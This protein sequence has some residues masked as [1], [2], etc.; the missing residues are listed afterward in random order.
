LAFIISSIRNCNKLRV[1]YIYNRAIYILTSVQ[2]SLN[3]K[4]YTYIFFSFS[5]S[6]LKIYMYSLICSPQFNIGINKYVKV[7]SHNFDPKFQN[8]GWWKI[9]QRLNNQW[10]SNIRRSQVG[11]IAAPNIAFL[12]QENPLARKIR[13]RTGHKYCKNIMSS[14]G[15]IFNF[16]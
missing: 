16:S 8:G 15:S 7:S 3:Q 14:C 12:Y 6:C 13:Y 10:S 1:F 2:Q 5:N 9:V 4:H 11:V